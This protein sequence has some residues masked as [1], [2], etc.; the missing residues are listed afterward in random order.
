M[1]RIKVEKIRYARLDKLVLLL[2]VKL[3]NS[4]SNN[5]ILRLQ[6]PSDC[7]TSSYGNVN[8]LILSCFLRY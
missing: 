3:R 5:T 8:L 4:K 1:A 2:C 6:S 7:I